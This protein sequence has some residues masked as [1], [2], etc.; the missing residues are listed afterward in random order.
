M[1]QNCQ[2]QNGKPIPIVFAA[3]RYESVYDYRFLHM[4]LNK[5]E[6]KFSE[7]LQIEKYSKI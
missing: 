3:I 4:G 6:E 2:L 7:K 5:K 1:N